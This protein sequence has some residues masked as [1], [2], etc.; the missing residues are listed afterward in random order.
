LRVL[1]IASFGGEDIEI[2][3]YPRVSA[4]LFFCRLEFP[5]PP[6]GL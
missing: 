2:R 5:V 6:L 1:V 3:V 4:P